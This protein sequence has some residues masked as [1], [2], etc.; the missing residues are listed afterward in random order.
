ML[1]HTIDM[2]KKSP[3]DI[4]N[5][6]HVAIRKYNSFCGGRSSELYV[7]FFAL[8]GDEDFTWC[9]DGEYVEGFLACAPMSGKKNERPVTGGYKRTKGMHGVVRYE[10]VG[11]AIEEC[12]KDGKPHGLRVVCTQ[13]GDIWIRLHKNGERLA[14]IVL[15][16]DLSI[17]SKL[18]NGGLK[19]LLQNLHLIRNCFVTEREEVVSDT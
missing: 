11:C 7:T 3:T 9:N 19:K 5:L 15:N 8:V 18:D 4:P 6:H 13:M 16:A 10:Y 12:R 1:S 17:Q 14:Q 2:F